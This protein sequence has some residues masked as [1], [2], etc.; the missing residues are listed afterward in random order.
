V[1]GKARA[2]LTWGGDPKA[3]GYFVWVAT[4]APLAK[5]LNLPDD[6]TIDIEVRAAALKAAVEQA[7]SNGDEDA[8]RCFSRVNAKPLTATQLQIELPGSADTLFIYRISGISKASVESTRSHKV[9]A[10]SVPRRIVPNQPTLLLRDHPDGIEIIAVAARGPDPDGYTLLRARNETLARDAGL[11]GPPRLAPGPGW[12]ADQVTIVDKTRK[13]QRHVDPA[14]PSWFPYFYRVRAVGGSQPNDDKHGRLRGESTPSDAQ[15]RLRLPP[16]PPKALVDDVVGQNGKH[17]ANVFT[18]Y[19]DLPMRLSP[20]GVARIEVVFQSLANGKLIYTVQLRAETHLLTPHTTL[21]A[22]LTQLANTIVAPGEIQLYRSP[23]DAF[24]PRYLICVP[25]Y[26]AGTL[27][28]TKGAPNIIPNPNGLLRPVIGTPRFVR[29]TDPLG[30]ITEVPLA[31]QPE[32]LPLP[33]LM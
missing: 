33:I 29:L 24:A 31:Q 22:N 18:L 13:A 5:M 30:R 28:K 12:T 16:G 15:H 1:H 10:V 2:R 26:P 25:C 14:P 3:L 9:F 23:T 8:I 17:T 27:V 19:T 11:M 20:L 4:E 21:P 32:P 6:P 7:A